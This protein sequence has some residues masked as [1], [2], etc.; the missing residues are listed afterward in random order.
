MPSVSKDTDF[1]TQAGCFWG[2]ELGDHQSHQQGMG[3]SPP[4]RNGSPAQKKTMG[5]L[6]QLTF[7]YSC[8]IVQGRF[9]L[10]W[11]N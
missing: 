11:Y 6:K 3:I 1:S 2:A 8:W 5:F 10:S 7:H 9:F 4:V